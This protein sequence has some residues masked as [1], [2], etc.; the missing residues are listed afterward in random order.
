MAAPGSASHLA[1]NPC[2]PQTPHCLPPPLPLSRPTQIAKQRPFK[3]TQICTATRVRRRHKPVTDNLIASSLFATDRGLAAIEPRMT[4]KM[5]TGPV[6][7][8]RPHSSAHAAAQSLAW[9]PQLFGLPLQ[10]IDAEEKG[11]R[12]TAFGP[13]TVPT[14]SMPCLR[15]DLRP[16]LSLCIVFFACLHS[17]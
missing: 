3:H 17:T 7:L 10:P 12:K 13:C 5:S 6:S 11:A 15:L 16:V 1:T 4:P 2:K 8:L 9:R 14:C